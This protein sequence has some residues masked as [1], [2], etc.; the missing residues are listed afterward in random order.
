VCANLEDGSTVRSKTSPATPE[1]QPLT[2]SLADYMVPTSDG[3]PEMMLIHQY[4][5]SPFN[6]RSVKRVSEGGAVAPPTAIA[7]A[8][9]DALAPSSLNTFL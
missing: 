1:G 8:V 5:P 9:A 6:A 4:S 3:V 2:G 7:N